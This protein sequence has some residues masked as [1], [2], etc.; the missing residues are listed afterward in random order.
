MFLLEHEAKA[1]LGRFEVPVPRGVL[2]DDPGQPIPL[3]P[4]VVVKAQV[5]AGGRGKAGGVRLARTEAEARAHVR[6]LLGIELL[7][8]RVGRVLV[9]EAVPAHTEGYVS[10][11]LDRGVRGPVLMAS[12][13]G[14]VDVERSESTVRLPVDPFLGLQPYA[15]RR[16]SAH[17]GTEAGR[18]VQA[19]WRC[20]VE[21]ECELVEVNP[22]AVTPEGPVAL[23]AKIVVDDRALGRHP[24]LGLARHETDPLEAAAARLAVYPVRMHGDIAV[25]AA[26]AGALM[27]TLDYVQALG[28]SL[29]GGIDLGGV[30]G[31]RPAELIESLALTREFGPKA[32]LFNFYVR[33]WKG[34]L[35]AESVLKA[36]GDL[37]PRCP[38]VVRLA[39]H[40]AAEGH[41]ILRA[42]GIPVTTSL[43]DACRR[44]VDAAR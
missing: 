41:A 25:A 39:G 28:G 21:C 17:L 22:L 14:G 19:L 12:A 10:L 20:F 37:H 18:V 1:L 35:L 42:A 15:A 3:G 2:L 13:A 24:E 34:D 31:H 40:R 9:E 44:T 27:A 11:L 32:F 36:V 8:Q 30:V 33:T 16:V 7:G 29:A 5:A 6:A 23:D 26:G 43:V 38:V 4:P